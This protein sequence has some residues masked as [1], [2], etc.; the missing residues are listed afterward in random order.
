MKCEIRNVTDGD[1]FDPA[2][3]ESRKPVCLNPGDRIKFAAK[4]FDK[5]QS[6]PEVYEAIMI[7]CGSRYINFCLTHHDLRSYSRIS[8]DIATDG[9]AVVRGIRAPDFPASFRNFWRWI[10]CQS[11]EINNLDEEIIYAEVLL[12]KP[13]RVSLALMEHL[14]PSGLG[15]VALVAIPMTLILTKCDKGKR[16]KNGGKRPDEN[17]EDF[18]KWI[19][20]FFEITP[21]WIMTSSAANQD[22][23]HNSWNR[24]LSRAGS[25]YIPSLAALAS[26]S[27][28]AGYIYRLNAYSKARFEDHE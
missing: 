3:V 1:V 15:S 24:K 16:Q 11:V 2:N 19:S 10:T 4:D 8:L 27:M 28:D 9:A 14:C 7:F 23:Q 26:P 25:T 6:N 22:C 20:G 17:V 13:F 21:P 18:Q 12:H 5:T